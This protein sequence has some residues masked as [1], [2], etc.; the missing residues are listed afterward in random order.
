MGTR[1]EIQTKNGN[2]EREKEGKKQKKKNA[3]EKED[4][5][6]R[7]ISNTCISEIRNNYEKKKTICT[8]ETNY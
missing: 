7:S 1:C 5:I 3:K 6:F 4:V 8:R 2:R